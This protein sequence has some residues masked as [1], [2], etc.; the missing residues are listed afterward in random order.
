MPTSCWICACAHKLA[1]VEILNLFNMS[2]ILKFPYVQSC[3]L[4]VQDNTQERSIDLKPAVVLD[5]SELSEFV[6]EKIDPGTGCAD[7]FRQRFLRHFREYSVGL[8]F[9]AITGQQ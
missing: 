1:R 6:H 9:L 3:R 4:L 5:E 2:H 7:H 8:V